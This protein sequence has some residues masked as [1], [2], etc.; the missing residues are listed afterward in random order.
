MST[1]SQFLPALLMVTAAAQPPLGTTMPQGMRDAF[2][3][4]SWDRPFAAAPNRHQQLFLGSELPARL[5]IRGL[6]LRKDD[7]INSYGGRTID[8]EIRLAHTRRDVLTLGPDFAQNFDAG[9]PTV[10]LPRRQLRLDD[11]PWN[12]PA[13]PDEFFTR[14]DF[15]REFA[16]DRRR[17]NLLLEVVVYGNDVNNQAFLYPLDAGAGLTTASVYA[18]GPN[19]TS[20][21]VSRNGIAIRFVTPADRKAAWQSS[22]Q[23]AGPQGRNAIALAGGNPP[24]IGEVATFDLYAPSW[25]AGGVLLSTGVNHAQALPMPGYQL[26]LHAD[27][28][29]LLTVLPLTLQAGFQTATLPLPPERTLA[30]LDVAFQ[31]VTLA[32][33]TPNLLGSSNLLLANVGT[34]LVGS[35]EFAVTHGPFSIAR[36]RYLTDANG[37][38]VVIHRAAADT[39]DK[40]NVQGT[41]QS[42]VGPLQI[43]VTNPQQVIDIPAGQAS[44]SVTV[45]VN[46]GGEVHL[47]NADN[48]Q[49]MNGVSYEVS[50]VD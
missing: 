5:D 6:A 8:V 28:A 49:T 15:A 41:K 30:G 45:K 7:R 21:V 44:Y 11:M 24:L 29:R 42:G 1:L 37:Q 17:G 26:T 47:Y 43:H 22:W 19:A 18:N 35:A 10:V 20:G 46:P 33:A 39:P 34:A 36:Q 31:A 16:F 9:A 23:A 32:T 3:P 4:G 38:T 48:A 14:I 40:I 25:D 12:P 13:T 27:L 50:V 2:G